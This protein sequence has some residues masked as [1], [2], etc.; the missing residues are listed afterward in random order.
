MLEKNPA[1]LNN[2]SLGSLVHYFSIGLLCVAFCVMYFCKS[3]SVTLQLLGAAVN[4]T[5][6]T[7]EGAGCG[8]MGSR[9]VA[10][11]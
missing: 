9:Q 10:F 5:A 6:D 4:M 1:A 3:P 7:W 11:L 8:T 2:H